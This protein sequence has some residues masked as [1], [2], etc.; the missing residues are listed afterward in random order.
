VLGTLLGC[1]VW[2]TVSNFLII[3]E[4]SKGRVTR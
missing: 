2:L 3:V 1:A 4:T